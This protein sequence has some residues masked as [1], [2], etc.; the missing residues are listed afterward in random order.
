[1][2]AYIADGQPA[3]DLRNLEG[4]TVARLTSRI[5]LLADDTSDEDKA[6]DNGDAPEDD[7]PTIWSF[8]TAK[9]MFE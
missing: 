7:E 4:V 8:A 1:M 5:V 2:E 3:L 9:G 6:N